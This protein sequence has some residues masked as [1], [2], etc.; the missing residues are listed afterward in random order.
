M[1]FVN[2][3]LFL[4]T[5]LMETDKPFVLVKPT[6]T[7]PP[8]IA[9]MG[10]RN[11]GDALDNINIKPQKWPINSKINGKVHGGFARH[12]L[13]L[14][15]SERL[16]QFTRDY[17]EFIISGHSLGGAIAT[18]YASFI[19]S[20][21]KS[22]E[23]IHTFGA[24]RIASEQFLNIYRMQNLE[25]ITFRYVID[26]DPVSQFSPIYMH[27]GKEIKLSLPHENRKTKFAFLKPHDLKSYNEAVH[28]IP[29]NFQSWI[30]LP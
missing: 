1:R 28:Q 15:E 20:N 26:G 5:L 2:L 7:C 24:P 4:T 9:F 22:I 11:W 27:L 3:N 14:L 25:E 21:G 16:K 29:T 19:V 6:V 30:F 23:S 18:L 12:T 17:D 13:N 8:I 10:T